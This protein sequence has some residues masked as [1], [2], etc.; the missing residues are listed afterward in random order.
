MIALDK[1]YPEPIVNLETERY[2]SAAKEGVLLL[3]RCADCARTHFYPRAL[4][5]HCMSGNTEW[6]AATGH[7]TIYSYSVMRK[8]PVPYAIAYVAL[9]EGVTMMSN[10]VECDLDELQIGLAVE[11]TFRDTAGAAKLPLFRPRQITT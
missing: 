8:V 2:W 11:V 5:P 6:F 7:G 9:D 1:E 4:C 3:K 10:I